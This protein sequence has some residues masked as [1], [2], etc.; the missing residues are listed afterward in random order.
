MTLYSTILFV[1]VVG[2]LGLV[3]ALGI[4]WVLLRYTTRAGSL[5]EAQACLRPTT[6]LP[7]LAIASMVLV[8][9]SGVYLAIHLRA[10]EQ[11]WVRVSLLALL[12]IAALGIFAGRRMRALRRAS[13]EIAEL[14]NDPRLQTPIRIRFSVLL[15]IVFL[16][17]AH[18][19]L[20]LSLSTM[21]AALAI[22]LA[23]SAASWRARGPVAGRA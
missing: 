5:E 16:M 17:V 19:N 15:G 9:I 2:M 12:F 23:W 13:A 8:L 6:V 14:V 22:G 20:A 4:E 1:H 11:A 21:G 18:T 3:T 7:P 10:G